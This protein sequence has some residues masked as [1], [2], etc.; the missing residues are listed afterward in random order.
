[1]RGARNGTQNVTL[2]GSPA[3]T[4][5]AARPG[6]AIGDAPSEASE[7]I[8]GISRVHAITAR[9]IRPTGNNV[10]TERSGASRRFAL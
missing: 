1:M 6:E 7:L 8:G 3:D 9:R 2:R 10:E 5:P 4:T